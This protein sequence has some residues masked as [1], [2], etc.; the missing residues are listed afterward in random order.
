MNKFTLF[1]LLLLS[2]NTQAQSE[3]LLS[4]IPIASSE[5]NIDKLSENIN[6][7]LH[8][9]DAMSLKRSLS[10]WDNIQS[11]VLSDTLLRVSLNGRAEFN[12]I[13]GQQALK[14]SFVIDFE[15]PSTQ[16][17]IQ[18][19][20]REKGIGINSLAKYVSEFITEPTYIH[21]FNIASRVASERSGDCT[22]YT[23]LTTALTRA[24]GMPARFVVGFVIY[25]KDD[26]L[27][28]FGHAWTEV[29]HQQKWQILDAALFGNDF[30]QL[31]YVPTSALD[32]E[33]PGYT[34]SLASAIFSFPS[35][36]EN[37]Q[38]AIE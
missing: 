35:R 23:T 14:G 27:A 29:L 7:D 31:Y 36:I 20:D 11:E 3:S 13:H 1:L 26:E 19:F 38:N 9:T 21:S 28:A 10:Q 12:Q 24:L 2:A 18:G 15:E 6:L 5:L 37:V 8:V 4:S 16:S 22:E 17:F 25:V 30:D 32:N 34:L 33:G